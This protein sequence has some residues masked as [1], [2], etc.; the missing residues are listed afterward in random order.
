MYGWY[1]QF[2]IASLG[3][4][5]NISYLRYEVDCL[6]VEASTVSELSLYLHV[7]EDVCDFHHF[8]PEQ[9][10]LTD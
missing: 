6:A 10:Q 9:D 4:G 5:E 7:V 2:I 1:C 3:Q 8:P